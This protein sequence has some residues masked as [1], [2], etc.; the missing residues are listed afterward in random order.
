MFIRSKWLNL[1]LDLRRNMNEMEKV[2]RKHVLSLFIVC[3][4]KQLERK[5]W[6]L[7]WFWFSLWI[8]IFL[9]ISVFHLLTTV[10]FQTEKFFPV[11]KSFLMQRTYKKLLI[12]NILLFQQKWVKNVT[13]TKGYKIYVEN[14]TCSVPNDFC[15]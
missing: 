5:T 9:F 10:I 7:I 8:L 6:L 15:F 12:N 3:F 2:S 1:K 13:E 14:I 4:K 11:K